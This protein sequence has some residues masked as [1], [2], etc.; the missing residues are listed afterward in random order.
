MLVVPVYAVCSMGKVKARCTA[1]MQRHNWSGDQQALFWHF[2]TLL[3]ENIASVVPISILL[4]LVMGAFFQRAAEEPV[5]LPLGLVAAIIGLTMF[6]DG[7]R[8]CVMPMA[9]YLGDNLPRKRSMPVTLV[10]VFAL[11]IL[12]TYAEPAIQSLRPLAAVVDRNAEPYLFF[13]LNNQ[14]E[15]LVLSIGLGV[16][17]AAG[18][19]PFLFLLAVS[20]PFGSGKAAVVDCSCKHDSLSCQPPLRVKLLAAAHQ[21][22]CCAAFC[23]NAAVQHL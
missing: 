16:G 9:E 19:L 21:G 18:E 4:L 10:V 8:V 23:S 3:F 6:V 7:L 22:G 20:F 13:V 12:V 11:G 5:L 2:N 1:W 15:L 17:V 14:Q